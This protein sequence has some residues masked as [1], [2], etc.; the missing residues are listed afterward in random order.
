MVAKFSYVFY[1]TRL[2]P[3]EQAFPMAVL[4]SVQGQAMDDTI[5]SLSVAC[6]ILVGEGIDL[7]GIA[8]DGDVKYLH[9]LDSFKRRI[10]DLRKIKL[11]SP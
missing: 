8:F 7:R 1:L 11:R 4:P 9:H 3:R 10:D 5:S 6:Q 2:D